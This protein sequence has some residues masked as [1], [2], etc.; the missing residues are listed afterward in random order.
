LTGGGGGE[1]VKSNWRCFLRWG[2]WVAPN[3]DKA[4]PTNDKGKGKVTK[5][6]V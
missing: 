4:T 5:V 3:A 6:P 1:F 2:G